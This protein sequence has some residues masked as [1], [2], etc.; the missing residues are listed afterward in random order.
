MI[1]ICYADNSPVIDYGFK[2]FFEKSIYFE[3][4]G[5]IKS[6]EELEE[7]LSGT[8]V[9]C[10]IFD[11][12]LEGMKSIQNIKHF[13]HKF[14]KV[15]FIIFSDVSDTLYAPPAIKAGVKGYLSKKMDLA[16]FENSIARVMNGDLIYSEEVAKAL[17]MLNKTK[18][19]DRLYKKLSTRELEVL[20]YFSEGKKNKE[21]AVL[22]GL[23]EKTISTYKLR[24]LQ[25][26]SA[27]N[28]IDLINKAKDLNII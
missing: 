25:K 9:H 5:G 10:A 22:L 17:E 16:E 2:S 13:I 6:R 28:L 21:V 20:R 18:K 4:F 1:K 23:D 8:D 3:Y 14:P 7:F 11:I 12:Q 24:L 26:L 15:K 27:T 19:Q